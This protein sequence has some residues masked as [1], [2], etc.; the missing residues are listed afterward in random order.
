MIPIVGTSSPI[1][2]S[3]YN[4]TEL[5]EKNDLEEFEWEYN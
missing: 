1:C 5:E 2:A 4:L 3:F